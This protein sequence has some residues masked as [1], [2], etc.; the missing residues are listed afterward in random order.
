[1]VLKGTLR[2]K[3]ILSLALISALLTG[4]TL[5]VVRR[6]VEVRVREEIVQG[7]QNSVVT[8]RSVD[9][10]RATMLERSAALLAALPPLKAVMTSQHTATIQDAS[11]TFWQLSGSQLFVLADSGGALMALHV[12]GQGFGRDA[13]QASLAQSLRNGDSRAW[14]YGG[15]R[16]FEVFLQPIYFGSPEENSPLG[17]LAVGYE[18]DRRVAQ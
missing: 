1:M 4:A 16:L 3:F 7:L 12:S 18:I 11:G 14:W 15:G 13:A 9:Q 17:T 10:Q 5:A 2:T 8:F 6:R